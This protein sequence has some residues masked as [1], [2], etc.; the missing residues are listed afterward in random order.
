MAPSREAGLPP[1]FQRALDSLRAAHVRPETVLAEVPAPQRL[2][3]YSA[4][5]TADVVVSGT[6]LAS[7]RFVV[8]YD[9]AGH[10]AWD[11][12]FRV[13]TLA[14]AELEPDIAADPMLAGVG[15]SWLMEALA[16]HEAPYAAPSGTVTRVHSESF[17]ALA[18]RPMVT[19]IE[20]RASWTPLD[21]DLGRHLAAWCDLLC[22]CAGVP[23]TPPG[24]VPIPGHRRGR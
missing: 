8:L 4:A 2:A 22:M 17:G 12:E 6:E 20:L 19:E 14:R 23:P 5:F 9:P 16:S 3:P 11:G 10:D 13:V 24:V 15:W 18:D 7:G 1:D 21:P